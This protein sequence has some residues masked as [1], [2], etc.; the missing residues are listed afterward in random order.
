MKLD[1]MRAFFSKIA[2]LLKIYDIFSKIYRNT[3]II[4]NVI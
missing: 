2:I 4:A 3:I 1:K